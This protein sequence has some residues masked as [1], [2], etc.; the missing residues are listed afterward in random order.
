M[1]C[2]KNVKL[3]M[4]DTKEGFDSKM[5]ECR[6]CEY[7]C[8]RKLDMK[9]HKK[10]KHGKLHKCRDCD[11]TFPE[12]CKLEKHIMDHHKFKPFECEKCD[13]TFVLKW[14]LTKH[15]NG[16]ETEFFCHYFNNGKECP[17]DKIGCKFRHG[18]SP[19]CKS[20]NCMKFLCPY[21]HVDEP[22]NKGDISEKQTE[23]PDDSFED[24]IYDRNCSLVTSTPKKKRIKRITCDKC[25]E[26]SQCEDCYLDGYVEDYLS[27]QTK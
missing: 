9:E 24:M 23:S 15:I 5:L 21:R 22:L 4:M 8:K 20:R 17:F 18:I 25:I 13:K 16:H 6:E 26:K 7:S 14:R 1:L 12:I 27:K 2:T 19:I 3:D 10:D 11:E